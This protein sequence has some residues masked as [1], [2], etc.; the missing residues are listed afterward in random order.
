MTDVVSVGDLITAPARAKRAAWMER[1]DVGAP[2]APHPAPLVPARPVGL[3]TP[4]PPAALAACRAAEAAG[5]SVSL[6]YARGTVMH[7]DGSAGRLV[8]SVSL[9]AWRFPGERAVALWYRPDGCPPGSWSAES[10]WLW[11]DGQLP[12]SVG[13]G[14]VKDAL[15]DRTAP[16]PTVKGACVAC[17]ALVA[18]TKAGALRVH[19]PKSARCIGGGQRPLAVTEEG[20]DHESATAVLD[21][22]ERRLQGA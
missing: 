13:V 1:R 10:G 9:R 22:A 6:V 20:V 3:D 4:C 17:G 8:E 14:A 19:G 18:I 21:S 5:W 16:A 15:A 2:P 12:R 7:A 11:V